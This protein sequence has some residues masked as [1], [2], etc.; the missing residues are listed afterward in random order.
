MTLEPIGVICLLAGLVILWKG[1]GLG[2]YLF[3]PATLLGA[4][5]AVKLPALGGASIQPAYILLGFLAV[6]IVRRSSLR[7]AA[8]RSLAFPNA[9][10]W[11]ALFLIYGCA[12]AFFL[13][14]IFAN[15]TYVFSLARYGDEIGIELVPLQPRASNVTYI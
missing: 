2:F 9:G 1:P 15:L 6:S 4:A 14:R 7:Q 13:P 12:S 11:L 3:C 8:F 5:A 10:F